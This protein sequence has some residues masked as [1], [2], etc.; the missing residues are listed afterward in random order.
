MSGYLMPGPSF[1][2]TYVIVYLPAF[3]NFKH[4]IHFD[5]PIICKADTYID[6]SDNSSDCVF[7]FN[8]SKFVRFIPEWSFENMTGDVQDAIRC[9]YIASKYDWWCTGCYKMFV[10]S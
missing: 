9:L 7:C 8:T 2:L 5:W 3:I 10:Y 6:Q 4:A 1:P